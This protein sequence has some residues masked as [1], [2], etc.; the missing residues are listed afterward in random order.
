MK[1]KFFCFSPAVMLGTFLIELVLAIYV[2]LRFKTSRFI[3]LV[4]LALVAL[5]A[6]QLAEYQ[7]CGHH[8]PL[9][10]AKIGF[11]SI[12][13]LPVI[14]L[15]LVTI[16]TN[17]KKKLWWANAVAALF[18]AGF[19]FVP[20]AINSAVCGGNYNIF[21]IDPRLDLFFV[22]YYPGLLLLG[23]IWAGQGLKRV[24]GQ[25]KTALLW[26]IIG[27]CSFI[28]PTVIIYILNTAARAGLGSIM[29][30]FAIILAFI[31]AFK[32]VPLALKSKLDF[33]A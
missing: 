4:V 21:T 31:L 28:M 27:Y 32:I 3:Q 2:W 14:G 23:L 18:I 1:P 8:S 7:I 11:V 25:Q 26:T 5:S 33:R 12:T 30:G 6:F 20:R 9:L 19:I 22:I 17:R 24:S 10:W 15:H 29:C 16:L 13:L